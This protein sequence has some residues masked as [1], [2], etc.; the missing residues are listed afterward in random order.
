MK[1]ITATTQT[2]KEYAR[3]H[4]TK[5]VRHIE[6]L[7]GMQP[8]TIN[9]RIISDRNGDNFA[10]S[11]IESEILDPHSTI[12]IKVVD[13]DNNTELANDL[14]YELIHA[15]RHYSL[16]MITKIIGG[17]M[18][19]MGHYHYV[20]ELANDLTH[21]LIHALISFVPD[22]PHVTELANDLAY[23]LIPNHHVAEKFLSAKS[24]SELDLL[25]KQSVEATTV[26]LTPILADFIM[27]FW[28]KVKNE[29]L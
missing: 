12:Y 15:L 6:S 24:F 19:R 10:G 4:C 7:C 22:R 26:T 2:S 14:A 8:D 11:Y 20:T 25:F 1:Q 16:L 18:Y 13:L 28:E 21:E 23:E 3:E 9:V 17:Q 29:L 5:L 27:R